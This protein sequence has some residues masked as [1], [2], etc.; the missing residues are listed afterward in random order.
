MRAPSWR[1]GIASHP[2]PRT[3]QALLVGA[4]IVPAA[5]PFLGASLPAPFGLPRLLLA[6]GLIALGVHEVSRT[7]R[8]AGGGR[9]GTQRA[10]RNLAIAGTIALA[11]DA[12]VRWRSTGFYTPQVLAD[13]LAV[14]L[15]LHGLGSLL[16]L[17]GGE[18]EGEE[19]PVE[20]PPRADRAAS[21]LRRGRRGAPRRPS[22]RVADR[23]EGVAAAMVVAFWVLAAMGM[24]E[25]A[26][27]QLLGAGAALVVT[28]PM[29]F[30]DAWTASAGRLRA[31]R[32]HGTGFHGHGGPH[33][34]HGATGGAA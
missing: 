19:E 34:P 25:L 14:L 21:W 32:H 16:R 10:L 23:I 11:C 9:R 8:Q 4:L 20:R 33:D 30:A 13:S 29:R 24:R 15:A 2:G 31:R 5:A 3:L 28:L 12:I 18:S 27:V 22:P 17:F 6:A 7:W 26:G 1:R